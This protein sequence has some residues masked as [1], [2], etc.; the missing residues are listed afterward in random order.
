[1]VSGT[2]YFVKPAKGDLS[3]QLTFGQKPEWSERSGNVD[4]WRRVEEEEDQ[5]QTARGGSL[6]GILEEPSTLD[7]SSWSS[8][9]EGKASGDKVGEKMRDDVL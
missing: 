1:M 8:G 3:E 5:G 4:I 6:G 7:R 2:I 9:P